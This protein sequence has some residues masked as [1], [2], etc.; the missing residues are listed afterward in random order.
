[1]SINQIQQSVAYPG[2]RDWLSLHV[3]DLNIYSQLDVDIELANRG[4][5]LEVQPDLSIEWIPGGGSIV[6]TLDFTLF[7][8]NPFTFVPGAT[9][10]I[11]MNPVSPLPNAGITIN[12]N[13]EIVFSDKGVYYMYMN[14]NLPAISTSEAPSTTLQKY[15]VIAGEFF[16]DFNGLGLTAVVPQQ[17]VVSN[18]QTMTAFWYIIVTDI[19]PSNNRYRIVGSSAGTNTTVLQNTIS[20]L[21]I[22]RIS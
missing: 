9:L 2:Y 15:S 12:A 16:N 14:F 19:H 4:D 21:S 7:N 3:D 11:T 17:G 6:A 1:M 20:S 18:P 13:G 10:P 22:V 8:P 5:I